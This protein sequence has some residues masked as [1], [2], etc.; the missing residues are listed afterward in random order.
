MI[1]VFIANSS[2]AKTLHVGQGQQYKTL[3]QAAA[4]AQPGDKIVVHNGVYTQREN[5]S[6]LSGD[7]EN[8][9]II[10]AEEEGKVI[11]RD[12][13][14]A[15]HL[16]S[17]SNLFIYGFIFESQTS[18]GVNI[19]D[20]GNYDN[21]TFNIIIKN[22]TF[23]N[24]NASGNND[25]LKLSG[26][27]SITVENC[28][29]LNG[30]SGGSGIDMVGCHSSKFIKN[31]FKNMGS[32]CIQIKGGS[33]YIQIAQNTFIDGGKRALNLGGSTGLEYFRPQNAPFEAADILVYS[34]IFIRSWA[35]I[36]YVGSTGVKV[37]NNTFYKPENWV[38]RILQETVD[39]NR[40][41]AC[42]DNEFSNNIIYFGDNLHRIVNI[43][44]NTRPETFA[45][46][47]NLW[48]N[49]DNPDFD[50]PQLP[51][52]ETNAIIQ[53]NPL[54]VS[55]NEYNFDLAVSSPAIGNGKSVL[56]PDL[57]F[58]DRYFKDKCSIGAFE[59]NGVFKDFLTD[60]GTVWYYHYN[61]TITYQTLRT[62]GKKVIGTNEVSI[63][64]NDAISNDFI[65]NRMNFNLFTTGGI[66]YIGNINKSDN[67]FKV[68]YDYNLNVGDTLFSYSLCS[69]P[70][71]TYIDSV[72]FEFLAGKVR[73][74]YITS[75]ITENNSDDCSLYFGE[76]GKLV[77]GIHSV[78]SFMLGNANTNNSYSDS[79]RCYTYHNEKGIEFIEHFS[80][81]PC[82]SIKTFVDDPVFFF[83]RIYP[84]PVKENL[85]ILFNDYFSGTIGIYEISGRRLLYNTEDKKRSSNIDV[86]SLVA[87]IYFLE[88][89]NGQGIFVRKFVKM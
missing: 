77:E 14:E 71:L 47:N 64:E 17:C 55:E 7:F 36:A 54:F 1:L 80:S 76:Q 28:V 57:D 70:F 68:L 88:I 29:F 51:A 40:F 8:P 45:F 60:S 9:I 66:T 24:M 22:C 5:I 20:S 61:N 3:Q 12:Q 31:K 74:V 46:S 23:R 67:E 85:N 78:N 15:W 19:D 72:K 32:N 53:Q 62:K 75:P 82:D 2:M 39:T 69:E 48:Y 58:K 41:V 49:F 50:D 52:E 81:F 37:F 25:L 16:S 59:Y 35:P 65:D 73:K 86:S 11:Y 38:F 10:Y 33:Q 34:N 87:G 56:A 79:L 18:N 89:N 63:I 27:N 43:G 13:S 4:I 26:V 30:A 84:N 44:P 42:G 21:S 6:N 83:Y